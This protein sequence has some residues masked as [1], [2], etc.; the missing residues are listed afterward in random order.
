MC[1][2]FFK[3]SVTPF[4]QYIDDVLFTIFK[5]AAIFVAFEWFMLR[6]YSSPEGKI[7]I[8]QSKQ[9][10]AH[11]LSIK[12]VT[13]DSVEGSAGYW[14]VSA[15]FIYLMSQEIIAIMH[16][17]GYAEIG[18]Y[19]LI[20]ASL[21]GVSGLVF[22]GAFRDKTNNELARMREA[23][24]AEKT[25][26]IRLAKMA[27]DASET[28]IAV[29]DD[30]R[31]I[32]IFNAAFQNISGNKVGSDLGCIQ[33]EDVLNLS[34]FDTHVLMSCFEDTTAKR[35]NDFF[36]DNRFLRV[37]IFSNSSMDTESADESN[38]FNVVLR[39][40]SNE[41]ILADAV[42]AAQQ[43]ALE[44]LIVI[45]AI[46]NMDNRFNVEAQR[47]VEARRP[48]NIIPDSDSDESLPDDDRYPT[49]T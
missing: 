1:F 14:V 20:S 39:D 45:Q 40:V 49:D 47:G 43:Q 46:E 17:E 33:L 30:K 38:Y 12:S 4:S 21:F 32:V 37:A 25:A 18:S 7:D 2:A 13:W 42:S 5:I 26:T 23:Y 11:V 19:R 44:T 27:L 15:I 6:K 9:M 48:L 29:V 24:V 16:Q 35:E 10:K 8:Y 3:P 34:T 36:V 41:R 22:V 31:S 28:A